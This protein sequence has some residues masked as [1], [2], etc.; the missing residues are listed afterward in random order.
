MVKRPSFD[1]MAR[2][3]YATFLFG[4]VYVMLMLRWARWPELSREVLLS[5]W[6]LL[7]TPAII[8]LVINLV[9]ETARIYHTRR[10][11]DRMLDEQREDS[12][13]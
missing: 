9:Q 2:Y 8:M 10:R 3:R 11:I 4:I 6:F 13:P 1:R 5:M 12:V 7:T